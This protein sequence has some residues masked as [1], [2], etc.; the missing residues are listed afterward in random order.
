MR[1]TIV[2]LPGAGAAVIPPG[3]QTGPDALRLTPPRS[4]IDRTGRL[5]REVES[6]AGHEGLGW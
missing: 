5:V 4:F 2:A 6:R 1:V 3:D